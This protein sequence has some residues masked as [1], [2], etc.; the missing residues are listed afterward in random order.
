MR[1]LVVMTKTDK[2]KRAKLGQM[3]RER[4]RAMLIQ[5]ALRV[6]A[7][8]GFD[9][10][11]IDDFIEA[12]GVARGTFYNYFKTREDLLSAAAE[13]VADTVDA[14]ILPLFRDIEDPAR[15]I[16]IA[17]RQFIEMSKRR[18]DWGGLLVR[19]IPL[20]GGAVSAE[21]RRG[22]LYDLR[23]GRKS[24]R[25][26]FPS[27]QAALALSMGT[28]TLAIRATI[29]ESTPTTFSEVIAT[30]ILQGLGMPPS[31]AKRIAA[32]PL[33][34]TGGAAKSKPPKP[35]RSIATG[36]LSA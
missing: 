7:D 23:A 8:R 36:V 28:I 29:A 20:I 16:A 13:Y 14:E 3:K 25:F 12:A 24:G 32:L 19:M 6:I 4:T 11:T 2:Q 30:M 33:P 31:E 34:V 17:T 18:P 15:R 26:H 27:T 10:P 22:V 21:M 35:T 9:A 5:V 1:D